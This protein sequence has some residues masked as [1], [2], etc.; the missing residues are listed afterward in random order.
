MGV[1][2]RML[3]RATVSENKCKCLLEAV[4]LQ[5]LVQCQSTTAALE[6]W[7]LTDERQFCPELCLVQHGICPHSGIQCLDRKC[8]AVLLKHLSL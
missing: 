8:M 6:L 1:V 4:S 3:N 2:M 5:N 7:V